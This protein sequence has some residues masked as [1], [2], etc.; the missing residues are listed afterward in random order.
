Y[1]P[2]KE[3]ALYAIVSDLTVDFSEC[4]YAHEAIRGEVR[5]M[6]NVFEVAHP[7]TKYSLLKG[8]DTMAPIISK[9]YL[10]VELAKC[11]IC[12]EPCSFEIC[13]ACKLLGR[14]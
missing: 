4:P 11:R 7:G 13:Q 9:E 6:L 14:E 10:N 1:I 2:E 12:G 3:V 8:F 5:N